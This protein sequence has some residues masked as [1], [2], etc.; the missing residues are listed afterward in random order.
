MGGFEPAKDLSTATLDPGRP[1]SGTATY[2]KRSL[3]GDLA[4]RFLGQEHPTPLTPAEA[5]LRRSPDG[6]L[7]IDCDG[8]GGSV[9]WVRRAARV[10]PGALA[11]LDA[12]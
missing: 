8:S 7:E 1:F 9:A 12:R 10:A 2:A 11:V 6:S 3:T 5:R 4:V